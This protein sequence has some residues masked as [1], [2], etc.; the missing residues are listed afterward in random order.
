MG[1]GRWG[2][3]GTDGRRKPQGLSSRPS[4]LGGQRRAALEFFLQLTGAEVLAHMFEFLNVEAQSAIDVVAIGGQDVAP[5]VVRSQGETGHVFQTGPGRVQ[6]W[7]PAQR[8][9]N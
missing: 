8:I 5:D 9:G 1:E 4:E 3:P 2:K 7:R 6:A